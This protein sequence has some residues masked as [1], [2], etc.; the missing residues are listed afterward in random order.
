MIYN[1]VNMNG[2]GLYVFSSFIFTLVSFAG[3]YLIIKYQLIKEEKKKQFLEF[4]G[5]GVIPPKFLVNSSYDKFNQKRNVQ[6]INLNDAL[7]FKHSLVP[8][9]HSL[10]DTAP[11][12]PDNK[13]NYPVPMPGIT[14][15]R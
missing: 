13:G 5:G 6:I 11:V 4:I 8:E 12:N 2:Y 10:N 7:R 9:L 1:F 3:L 14:K 15:Y